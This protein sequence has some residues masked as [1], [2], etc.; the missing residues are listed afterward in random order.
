M[1]KYIRS[2]TRNAKAGKPARIVVQ[3]NSLV[4]Q[5]T[6]DDLYRASQAGV[7]IDLIVRGICNLVPNIKGVSENIRVRSILGRYLE[8]S[9]IFYFENS[10]GSQPHIFAGSADWMP[11]NFYRRIEAVFPIEDP[12]NRSRIKA[13]LEIYLKDTH[14]ARILRANGSYSKVSRKKG[15]YLMSAQNFFYNQAESKRNAQTSEHSDGPQS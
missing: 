11:R 13:L 10:S 14:H 3:T 1:Q 6:I 9:R 15:S 4:D 12:D 2:E 7:K 8:H 5:K